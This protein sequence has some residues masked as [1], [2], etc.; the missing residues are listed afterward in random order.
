MMEKRQPLQQM[1]QEKL[2]IHMKKTETKFL[3]LTLYQ[4]QLR[5]DQILKTETETT[6]GSSRKYTGTYTPWKDFPK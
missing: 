2:V 4:Y 3:P 6:I 5:V 1:L